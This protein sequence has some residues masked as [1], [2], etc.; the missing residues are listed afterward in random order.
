MPC[1]AA[2]LQDEDSDRATLSAQRILEVVS[3]VALLHFNACCPQRVIPRSMGVFLVSSNFDH[4]V[5]HI[6]LCIV[7]RILMIFRRM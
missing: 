6:P 7:E 2:L 5:P 3:F 4:V 1:F